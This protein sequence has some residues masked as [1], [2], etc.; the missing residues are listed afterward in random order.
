[1]GLLY[2]V[3]KQE[4]R[5]ASLTYTFTLQGEEETWEH[6]RYRYE[7]AHHYP[8]SRAFLKAWFLQTHEEL[9]STSIV[10]DQD[11][12]IFAREA[13]KPHWKPYTPVAFLPKPT[14]HSVADIMAV[15][16]QPPTA[17]TGIH[18]ADLQR[19]E[20]DGPAPHYICHR[21]GAQ[22]K[23]FVAYCPTLQDQ[24]FVAVCK[25]KRPKG[26]PQMFLREAVTEADFKNAMYI[27]S[28]DRWVVR[29]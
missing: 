9:T 20:A 5:R 8:S 11:Q 12:L 1:M 6:V 23:H 21:C 4:L 22:G 15:A 13:M 17:E 27:E 19:Q 24:Y 14:V 10:T 7:R 28:D 25:R 2:F 3:W 26:I 29:R 18:P 16:R